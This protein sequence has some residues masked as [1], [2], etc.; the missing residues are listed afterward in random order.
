LL[1][2]LILSYGDARR[3]ADLAEGMLRGVICGAPLDS[4]GRELVQLR[5]VGTT[6]LPV[7]RQRS[8]G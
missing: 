7:D 6:L 2:I 4:V 3:H 5:G 8:A 1:I